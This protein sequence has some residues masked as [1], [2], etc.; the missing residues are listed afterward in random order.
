MTATILYDNHTNHWADLAPRMVQLTKFK[1]FPIIPSI[2]TDIH[3]ELLNCSETWAVVITAGNVVFKPGIMDDIV[4]FCK[5]ENSPLAGHILHRNGYYHL[6]PQFFCINVD[7]YKEWGGGLEPDPSVNSFVTV[8]IERSLDNVHDDYTPWWIKA[9]GDD[10]ITVN[11]PD[12]FASRYITWLVKKGHRIVN[13]PQE[14]R[15]HKIHSYVDH[16]HNDIRMFIKDTNHR[17]KDLGVNHFLSYL[18]GSLKGLDLGFYPINTEPVTK[19]NQS[20]EIDVF[21][22]VCGGIKP[23]IIT[24]QPY[25]TPNTKVILFDISSM[26][27]EW[28][29]WLRQHWDGRKN[30]LE[31]V[32][33]NF[34]NQYP[35]ALPQ[36]FGYMGILGNF[37]WVLQNT[38]SEQE[39]VDIWTHWLTLDVEFCKI[40]L[41]DQ[42]DQE[43]LINKLSQMGT[44]AYIWT[45]N[46]FYMDWQL[47]MQEPGYARQCHAQFVNLLKKSE[48]SILLENENHISFY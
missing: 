20:V 27:I 7:L 23:A 13:I 3:Q 33:E 19:I 36:Y 18:N 39:F 22:G 41:L 31:T 48:L 42:V 9:N 38:C 30:S 40:N 15:Q 11:C 29:R 1:L 44:N 5:R 35:Q 4:E 12:G 21:A 14:I 6:H 32:F 25:F 45:S 34:K 28:Q 37:E 10:V 16:N 43:S 17:S 2:T 47:I 26:A 8:P 24:N 46:L